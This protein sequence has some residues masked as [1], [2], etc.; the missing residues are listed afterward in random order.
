MKM[1]Q[2]GFHTLL[3]ADRPPAVGF[4]SVFFLFLFFVGIFLLH[5]SIFKCFF[6]F[7]LF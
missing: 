4:A 2:F 7:V 3:K 1:L 5:L 6:Y